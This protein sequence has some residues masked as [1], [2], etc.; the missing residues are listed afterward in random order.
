MNSNLILS[1]GGRRYGRTPPAPMPCNAT[2]ARDAGGL[3]LY[4]DLAN[5]DG[6]P[7]DQ[8]EEGSCTGHAFAESGSGLSGDGCQR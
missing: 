7:K 3:P 8:G 5:F 1:A 6:P 2:Q 4:G